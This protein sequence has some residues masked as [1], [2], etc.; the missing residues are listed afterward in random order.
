MPEGKTGPPEPPLALYNKG[1]ADFILENQNKWVLDVDAWFRD[2]IIGNF[3][4]LR[5]YVEL[6]FT[7]TCS[8][9]G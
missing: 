7:V 4:G 5:Y 8:L 9:G 2:S 3:N 6:S 1:H